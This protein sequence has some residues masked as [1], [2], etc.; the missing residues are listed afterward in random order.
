MGQNTIF[1]PSL[2]GPFFLTNTCP[3]NTWPILPKN[4]NRILCPI[5]VPPENGWK[6]ALCP[7]VTSCPTVPFPPALN[8]IS[9]RRSG[10]HSG[11]KC[12][13]QLIFGWPNLSHCPFEKVLNTLYTC[14]VLH[15]AST[16]LRS[17]L[18]CTSQSKSKRMTL[19][20]LPRVIK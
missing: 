3:I 20:D 15:H 18:L 17:F 16:L 11:T 9:N 8:C 2:D 14:P 7:I 4:T 6:N 1:H 12:S 19:T 5:L 13:S 10:R